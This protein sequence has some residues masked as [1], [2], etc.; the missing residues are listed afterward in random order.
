MTK[1]KCMKLFPVLNSGKSNNSIAVNMLVVK[2]VRAS[3]STMK[4]F[5]F[6][7]D[8]ANNW[9]YDC[10]NAQRIGNKGN[11]GWFM[12]MDPSYIPKSPCIVYSFGIGNDWSFD[13]SVSRMFNCEVHAFDPTIKIKSH[14]RDNKINFHALGLKDFDEYDFKDEKKAYLTLPSIMKHLNQ[15]DQVIDYLK[16][17]IETWEWPSLNAL[18]DSNFLR[19]KVKQLV[20]EF[21]FYGKNGLG[22][23]QSVLI[24]LKK[25]GL[26]LYKSKANPGCKL[27]QVGVFVYFNCFELHFVNINFLKNI[28]TT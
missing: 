27:T 21:H 28:P 20:A 25:N 15:S 10:K 6:F 22:Y 12:C 9:D 4:F 1:K 19:Y 14:M 7:Q 18:S 17:D 11:G 23:M 2:N 3:V 26:R 13:D 24:K 5:R 8:Y 16:I